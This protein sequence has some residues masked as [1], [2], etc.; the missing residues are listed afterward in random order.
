M[1]CAICESELHPTEECPKAQDIELAP[2]GDD[3][4]EGFKPKSP[5][6][7]LPSKKE[8]PPYFVKNE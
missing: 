8:K 5:Q 7:P 3:D 6:N 4:F 2:E 1:K